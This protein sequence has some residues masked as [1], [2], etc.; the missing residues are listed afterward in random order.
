MSLSVARKRKDLPHPFKFNPE[1]ALEVIVYLATKLPHPTILHIF[2]ILYYAD[3][4]HLKNYCSFICG[5]KYVAME[6]GAVP[7]NV[8]DIVK[9][10]NGK[11]SRKYF[12]IPSKEAFQVEGYKIIPL[13]E[14]NLDFLSKSN[15]EVLDKSIK[16]NGRKGFKVL[17]NMTHQE[18]AWINADPFTNDMSVF[19]IASEFEFGENLVEI[20][21]GDN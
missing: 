18:K 14:P 17:S 5:D 6:N 16:E 10:V 15:I 7:S 20:L 1:K 11:H 9:D 3:K 12:D 2:K 8:Y 4:E 19:D 21:R 13:R